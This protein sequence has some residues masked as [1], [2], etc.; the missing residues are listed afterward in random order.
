MKFITLFSLFFFVFSF[1]QEK[2]ENFTLYFDSGSFLIDEN[3]T[4]SL[5]FFLSKEN[6]AISKITV[7]GYCDDVG[8]DNSNIILSEKR[9]NEVAKI[10]DLLLF[11][12]PKTVVGKGEISL[13]SEVDA[14]SARAK[15]RKVEIVIAFSV[16]EKVL[17]DD[18]KDSLNGDSGYKNLGDNLKTGDKIIINH[19]LFV[20]SSTAFTDKDEAE[21]ELKKIVTYFVENPTIEFEINGH[22]CCITNYF[23]DARNIE[24]GLNNLSKARAEKVYNYFAA[25]GIDKNRMKH[26][27]FGRKYPRANVDEKLNKRVEIVITKV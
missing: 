13:E 4:E 25:S 17:S 15:N 18:T 26:Q 1:S 20:G 12:T 16:V 22:V 8:L 23:K 2:T 9:A 11:S 10:I 14:V 19:L 24:T 5:I 3:K 6:Y 27:G 7:E 21:T